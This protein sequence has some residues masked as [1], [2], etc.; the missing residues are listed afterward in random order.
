MDFEPIEPNVWKPEKDGDE[1]MGVL[2]SSEPS[3]RYDNK[4]YHLEVKED[5]KTTQK[6][7]F[8]TTVLD[9]RMSY[10]KVGDVVKIIF[11]GIQKNQKG[12]DV[13]IFQVLKGK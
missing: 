1:I 11:K 9:D 2:V 13:K 4:V 8:G 10:I 6:V 5:E 3:P 12:Q 7:V